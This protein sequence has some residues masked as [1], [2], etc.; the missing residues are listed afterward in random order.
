MQKHGLLPAMQHD[1]IKYAVYFWAGHFLYLGRLE[2]VS[3]HTHHALQVI[4]NREGTFR[5]QVK[6]AVHECGGIIIRSDHPHRLLTSNDSQIHLWIERESDAAALIA[7]RHLGEGNIKIL[8]GALLKRVQNCIGVPGNDLGDCSRAGVAY[9]KI[10]SALCGR[11]ASTRKT[12]DPRIGAAI[13]MVK[14]E[15][16]TRKLTVAEIARHA[17]LSESRF[18]HLFS[19]EVGIPLRRYVLWLRVISAVHSAVQGM[20]LTHAAHNAGFSD[21]AHLSRTYRRMFGLTLSDCVQYSRFVQ[22]F[23]CLS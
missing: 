5:L 19:Q 3:R 20:T 21:S 13:R 1:S 11:R 4:V 15:Y 16:L 18:M 9:K 7:E 10:V 6:G 12:I 17:C 14:D 8:E 23:P 22:A 2:D